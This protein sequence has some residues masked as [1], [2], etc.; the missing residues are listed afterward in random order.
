MESA[1]QMNLVVV[2]H[3]DHGK[4]TVVGRLLADTDSLPHGKLDAVRAS[5]DRNSRPFEYAFL[6][7]ALKDE[8]AQGIT[9]DTSRCFFKSKRRSYII[10]DAPGHIEFLKNMVSG[11]ARAEAAVL[12]IDAAEGVQE[13]SKRH[14]FMVSM[15]GIRQ[16]IVVINKMD[17]VGYSQAVYDQVARE[18]QAFLDRIHIHP[19]AIIPISARLGENLITKSHEMPWFDGTVLDAIDALEKA[20]PKRN[21]SFRFPVQD[22]YKFTALGDN[23]RIVAGTVE[24][25]VAKVGDEIVFLPSG[26]T[27]RIQ[28]IEAFNCPQQTQVGA[29]Q[30][31]GLTLDTQIYIKPGDIG[32]IKSDSAPKVGTLI[33]GH[34]FWLGK[35]PMEMGRRYQLKVGTAK[36]P[37]YL[38]TIISVMDASNL[39]AS[40]TKKTIGRNEVAEVRFRTVSPIACDLFSENQATGRFVIVDG[41]EIS[42]GGIVVDVGT[43]EGA[44]SDIDESRRCVSA[45]AVD[46]RQAHWHPG[47]I[48]VESIS[49]PEIHRLEL[50]LHE[51]GVPVYFAGIIQANASAGQTT[52]AVA[53]HFVYAGWICLLGSQSDVEWSY[54]F[55]CRTLQIPAGEIEGHPLENTI[56]R[57]KSLFQIPQ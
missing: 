53:S 51:R 1:E 34:L 30:A 45:V 27:S 56:H 46:K 47:V 55:P 26:K 44:L 42:G 4:S 37:M 7:D 41:Y 35:Q 57:I 16:I 15:L 9:I 2:G 31:I 18:Y 43:A 19:Q 40:D 11:A 6:L 21:Q 23:R 49:I 3:V 36:V 13:N 12:I 33:T 5:C 14:G 39:A 54:E 50:A 10:I 24:T 32:H 25:G 28:T 52:L 48:V 8:Q 38:D 20:P 22:I 17:L 29:G